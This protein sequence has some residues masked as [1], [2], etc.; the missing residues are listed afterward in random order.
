MV[1][2]IVGTL[3]DIGR[4]RL[5]GRTVK[6]ILDMKDRRLAGVTAPAHGL[7][8]DWISYDPLPAYLLSASVKEP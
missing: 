6:Q 7:C 3:V 2:N 5:E 4:G 1:R 8:M